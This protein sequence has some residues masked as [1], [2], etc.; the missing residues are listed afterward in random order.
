[1]WYICIINIRRAG[2]LDKL[3]I[4]IMTTYRFVY[5]DRDDNDLTEKR[6]DC[7]DMKDAEDLKERLLGECMINDCV[8][9]EIREVWK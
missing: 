3:C 5:V 4:I 6:F 9:I 1:M 8:D 7:F 2:Q